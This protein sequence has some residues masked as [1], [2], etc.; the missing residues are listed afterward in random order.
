MA[1]PRRI[2][3]KCIVVKDQFWK[4][5]NVDSIEARTPF[6]QS[7]D[8]SSDNLLYSIRPLSWIIMKVKEIS[9]ALG[10]Y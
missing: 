9:S 1:T 6:E 4:I 2:C 5:A 3:P 8:S 7:S 10:Q